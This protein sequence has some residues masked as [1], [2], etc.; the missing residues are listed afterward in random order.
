VKT[1]TKN[2]LR[3][4]VAFSENITVKGRPQLQFRSGSHADYVSGSG[5]QR[6]IF[7]T[8]A[9]ALDPVQNL[10]LHGGAILATEAAA[11]LRAADLTLPA[12]KL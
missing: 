1:I 12:L 8:T 3:F 6:L 10:D 9:E 7:E 11:T 2:G 5:G 4:E